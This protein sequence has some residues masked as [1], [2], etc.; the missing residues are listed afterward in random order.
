MVLTACVLSAQPFAAGPRLHPAPANSR[1][2]ARLIYEDLQGNVWLSGPGGTF[3]YDGVRYVEGAVFGLPAGEATRIDMSPDGTVWM[4]IGDGLWRRARARFVQVPGAY[5]AMAVAG[6]TV[7]AMPVQKGVAVLRERDGKWGVGSVST[8]LPRQRQIEGG[9]D[10][11]VWYGATQALAWARWDGADWSSGQ[12]RFVHQGADYWQVV[13]AGGGTFLLTDGHGLVTVQEAQKEMVVAQG[14]TLSEASALKEHIYP[15]PYGVWVVANG[16]CLRIGAGNTAAGYFRYAGPHRVY[17]VRGGR[18]VLWA[19]AG[20][21]GLLSFGYDASIQWIQPSDK[22]TGTANSAFLLGGELF[23]G[24]NDLTYKVVRDGGEWDPIL[25]PK[26]KTDAAVHFGLPPTMAPYEASVGAPDGTIWH[27][28]RKEGAV[29]MSAKGQWIDTVPGHTAF[30]EKAFMRK[31]AFSQD[32]RLWIGSLNN[33]WEVTRTDSVGLLFS[34]YTN[35]TTNLWAVSRQLPLA[36][37]RAGGWEGK[38]PVADLVNDSGGRLFAVVDGGLVR[39]EGGKWHEGP[40]PACA[41]S[42]AWRTAAVESEGSLWF[43]Y[44]DRVGFTHARRQGVSETWNC[45]HYDAGNGF[46]ESPA[47]LRFDSRGWL[48][49]GDKQ[50]LWVARGMRRTE[51]ADWMRIGPPQGLADGEMTPVFLEEAD[52]GVVTGVGPRLQR[53]PGKLLLGRPEE[54][55]GVTGVLHGGRTLPAGAVV[56]AAQGDGTEL[57]ISAQAANRLLSAPAV[58]YRTGRGEWRRAG[59]SLPLDV[60][61]TGESTIELRFEGESAVR[62]VPVRVAAVWWRNWWTR[63]AFLMLAAV[64]MW[65]LRPAAR[66]ALYRME[67]KRFLRNYRPV[68]TGNGPLPPPPD[69]P[70][71]MMVRNRYRIESLLAQ[72]G[73]SDVFA[74]VDTENKA[75]VVIKRLRPPEPSPE[76]PPNWLKKRFLHEIG[77]ISL[78]RGAG[79]LP[80]LDTWFDAD[81]VPHIVMTRIDGGTLREYVR[82]HAPLPRPEAIYYMRCIAESIGAAHECGVVH[83]DIKPEN[84]LLPRVTGDGYA[85]PI[86]IDFGTAAL[87]LQSEALSEQ[88]QR[89]GTFRSMAP[90]Q[91]LGRYSP[92][93]DV[94]AYA[95]MALEI[96][97][98]VRYETLGVPIDK[99]WEVRFRAHLVEREFGART[100]DLLVEALRWDPTQRPEAIWPWADE[101]IRSME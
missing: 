50:G 88:T 89:A 74:A 28:Q 7:Y 15:S 21:A 35:T 46:P 12:L 98:G 45:T 10:G 66:R 11:R 58:E 16:V 24:R 79:I 2:D 51:P 53:I 27:L 73:F 76:R 77:V 3:L 64:G 85:R 87:H 37:R 33:L 71:G 40:A 30:G 41:L 55:P 43:S 65:R 18:R 31:L 29:Q 92:A 99:N 22:T 6:S 48:W 101:L 44:R 70:P 100:I 5:D 19:A 75:A 25:T 57:L 36:Y 97:G 84:I 72:G 9:A 80:V 13:P 62:K 91:L 20:A 54:A 81:G 93:S 86:V 52:G 94:Y 34:G 60:V 96:L 95:V 83:C 26:V 1:V 14:M 39:Y 69:W 56:E 49:R 67:K 90:E 42:A 23:F 59:M 82:R 17:S 4:L 78:I 8:I 47:L 68:R 38:R 32:G 61:G 63:G